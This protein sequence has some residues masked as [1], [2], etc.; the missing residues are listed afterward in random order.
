MEVSIHEIFNRIYESGIAESPAVQSLF[1]HA[2]MEVYGEE[3]SSEKVFQ[4]LAEHSTWTLEAEQR[5]RDV[6]QSFEG[7]MVKQSERDLVPA[8]LVN[9]ILNDKDL[10]NL[11]EAQKFA[12]VT[13]HALLQRWANEFSEKDGFQHLLD[14]VVDDEIV[15]WKQAHAEK[16]SLD[17]MIS[18]A[19]MRKDNP[20]SDTFICL[21]ANKEERTWSAQAVQLELIDL[22]G[23]T[24]IVDDKSKNIVISGPDAD[25][26][27]GTWSTELI[28]HSSRSGRQDRMDYPMTPAIGNYAGPLPLV[29]EQ[30]YPVDVYYRRTDINGSE[31]MECDHCT[32]RKDL[33][34]IL[35][36]CGTAGYVPVSFWDYDIKKGTEPLIMDMF[37]AGLQRRYEAALEDM[38]AMLMCDD[39]QPLLIPQSPRTGKRTTE[40]ER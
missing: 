1:T 6:L 25:N 30:S 13:D 36:W 7:C 33:L 17:D 12:I 40:R 4:Y 39:E 27:F 8:R 2:I 10:W 26:L 3:F 32:N 5:L 37:Q 28:N 29:K 19:E 11:T 22:T 14:Y 31:I 9:L 18:S 34:D 23:A 24:A 15:E 38:D 21:T 35:D 20:G 16:P